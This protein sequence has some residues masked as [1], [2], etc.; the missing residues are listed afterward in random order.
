MTLKLKTLRFDRETSGGAPAASPV[1]VDNAAPVPSIDWKRTGANIDATFVAY[2]LTLSTADVTKLRVTA[3]FKASSA[4]SAAIFI[5]ATDQGGR[6]LGNIAA[7]RIAPADIGNEHRLKL[8]NVLLRTLAVGQHTIDW[9]WERSDDGISGWTEFDRTTHQIF[10][11]LGQPAPPWGRPGVPHTIV[12]WHA[13]T[14]LACRWAKGKRDANA[15]ME[16]ITA[17]VDALAGT[18]I[19]R[20]GGVVGYGALGALIGGGGKMFSVRIL[21]KIV[22][23]QAQIPPQLN[24]RDLN[25]AVAINASL[26]GCPLRM[27][28]VKPASPAPDATFDTNPIK[29]FGESAPAAQQ[30][31][32]HEAAAI[33]G[34]PIGNRQVFDACV[35]V[36]FDTQPQLAP[37][38]DFRL[39]AGVAIHQTPADM[40]YRKRL[41]AAGEQG[42]PLEEVEIDGIRYP[43]DTESDLPIDGAA[44]RALDP[45]FKQ[46]REHF[47]A[48]LSNVPSSLPRAGS[49]QSAVEQFLS[50]NLEVRGFPRNV[51]IG[52]EKALLSFTPIKPLQQNNGQVDTSVVQAETRQQAIQVFAALAADYAGV[53]ERFEVGDFALRDPKSGV[54]L[55]LRGSVVAEISGDLKGDTAPAAMSE[56][57]LLDDELNR[58]YSAPTA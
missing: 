27:I 57:K 23:A 34:Q 33:P 25:T 37:P 35:R 52:E 53:L 24:C 10:V 56:A 47:A 13:V 50:G 2:P 9:K 7:T 49:P 39:P 30:F 58:F 6:V 12:P 15:A 1:R 54:V 44:S 3:T 28:R 4:P 22:N 5:R 31:Q 14:D 46:R 19:G 38:S 16:A 40:G 32:Y 51:M 29:V 21:L 20:T 43:G 41:L 8:E 26:I 18:P 45:F 11:T 17:A 55:M 48:L 42:C 36:D